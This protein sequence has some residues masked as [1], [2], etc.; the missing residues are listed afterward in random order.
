[1]IF[2]QILFI[3]TNLMAIVLM[4]I[5]LF[6]FIK[7]E[8]PKVTIANL[9]FINIILA[10]FFYILFMFDPWGYHRA[11]ESWNFA[12]TTIN[13]TDLFLTAS[14]ILVSYHLAKVI[15]KISH[16]ENL[17]IV[18]LICAILLGLAYT[19]VWILSLS[20]QLTHSTY[21]ISSNAIE[22]FRM[23][24]YAFNTIYLILCTGFFVHKLR[25]M[26]SA[27]SKQKKTKEVQ[28]K[29]LIAA[30]ASIWFCVTVSFIDRILICIPKY[31]YNTLPNVA[32]IGFGAIIAPGL[33]IC[34]FYL[35]RPREKEKTK[36]TGST[37]GDGNTNTNTNT[38]NNTDKSQGYEKFDN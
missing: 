35:F 32:I 11:I 21:R 24:I 7:L 30:T 2:Y 38:N 9:I 18:A 22:Y 10:S 13:T 16:K 3:S 20:I 34:Y 33:S 17:G 15:L 27:T 12:I 8:G 28:Y 5:R 31:F 19:A 14:L 37:T 4:S 36:Q 25:Q 1:M 6:Q 23:S 29:R 26:W